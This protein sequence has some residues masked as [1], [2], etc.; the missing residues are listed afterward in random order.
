MKRKNNNITTASLRSFSSRNRTRKKNPS[1]SNNVATN[2]TYSS[3]KQKSTTTAN[4]YA[5][6]ATIGSASKQTFTCMGC[7]NIF[8]IYLNVSDFMKKHPKSND[9]C[10]KAF[11]KCVCGK[12][13]YDEKHLKSHQ[14]RSSK[15]KECWKQY[16]RE[17]T[18]TK[19]NSSEVIIQPINSKCKLLTDDPNIEQ[20]PIISTKKDLMISKQPANLSSFLPTVKSVSKHEHSQLKNNYSL[21]V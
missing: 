19:F 13:F 6:K 4:K 16:Q 21:Q 8:R 11:P 10:H 3:S 5:K 7:K 20:N 14:S 18:N 9:K 2:K 12:I 17:I 15:T 1:I